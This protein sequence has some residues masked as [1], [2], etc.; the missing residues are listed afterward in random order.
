MADHSSVE[1]LIQN[2]EALIKDGRL[3]EARKLYKQAV[4]QN[5]E[6]VGIRESVLQATKKALDFQTVINQNMALAELFVAR[7]ETDRAIDSYKDILNLEKYAQNNGVRGAQLGEVQNLV[8]RAK[9]EIFAKTG[10]IYLKEKRFK[11][12]IK[13]LRTSLDLDP[14]RWDAHMA[15]GRALMEDNKNKEAIS[16]FQEVVRL[17]KSEAASAY[18]LL[19]EVFLRIGRSPQSTVDWFRNAGELFVQRSEF[20]GAIRAYEKILEF[21][22]RNKDILVRLGEIYSNQGL[23]DKAC[24]T[25]FTLAQ[26]FEEEGFTDRVM[27]YLEKTLDLN[28]AEDVARAKLVEVYKD[29]L[30]KDPGNNALRCRLV[31]NLLHQNN[32]AEAAKHELFLARSYIE[33]GNVDEAVSMLSRLIE[34]EPDNI[35]AHRLMGDQYRRKEMRT[36]SLS[37][38]QIVVGL[39]QKSGRKDESIEFQHQ[40][41]EIF[42]EISDLR[43]QVALSLRDQGNR[44]EA[45]TELE[46]L[47]NSNP[48]DVIALNYLAEEYAAVSKWEESIKAY[49]EI[50]RRDAKRID[51]RKRLIKYYINQSAHNEAYA[52]VMALPSDDF[53]RKTFIYKIIERCLEEDKTSEAEKFISDLSEDDDRLI[54]FRKEL[55]KRYLDLGELLQADRVV[56]LVPRSDKERNK[57]VTRLLELY[58]SSGE[59][60]KAVELIDRLPSDDSLRGSFQRR[61]INSYQESG[62]FED[63]AAEMKKLPEGDDS[64][65]DFMLR[66]ISGLLAADRLVDALSYIKRLDDNDPA[67][68]SFIGQLIEAYLQKND[69][70]G[71][72][73]E[74]ENLPENTEIRARYMCRII[75]AYLNNNRFD[76]AERDIMVLETNDPEKLSFLRLLLQKYEINGLVDRMRALV[77]KLPDEMPEKHQYL[78]GIVQSVLTSGNMA[79]ARQEVYSMAESVASSGNHSEAERLYGDLLAYNPVDV[80]IRMRLCQ[81]VALQGK[82]DRAREGLLVLAG[83]FRREGNATSATDIFSR[84]LAIE[85]DNLNARYRL[86]EIWAQHGQSSQALEQFSFLASEYL[87]Q[88]LNEVAQKVLHRILDLDPKDINHRRQLINLLVRNMRLEDATENYKV[89]LNIHLDRGELEEALNCIREVKQ[90]QP[91]NLELGQQLGGMVL[92]AGFLEEGQQLL[93][94]LVPSYKGRS[95]HN[96]V[97]KIFKTLSDA[98]SDNQQWEAA[99]EYL[100]RV[101]DEQVEAD[102]WKEAQSNYLH[103][104]EEHLMHSRKEYTDTLFVKLVD[105]FFRHKNVTEG[106]EL[107]NGLEEKFRAAGR[108]D[109]A[110]VIKER[111]AGIMER[112][113]DW[114]KAIEVIVYIAETD[115]TIGESE[116]GIAYYRR[117][118]DLAAGHDMFDKSVELAF[119]LVVLVL[120][121]HGFEAARPIF[122]EI[123]EYSNQDPAVIER[124]ADLMFDRGLLEEARPIYEE[125]LQKDPNSPKSISRL[126]VIYNLNE[127]VERAAKLSRKVV[128]GG[129]LSQVVEV[130]TKALNYS[131]SDAIYHIKLGQFFAQLGFLEESIDEFY[132]AVNDP[133]RMLC[134]VNSLSVAFQDKGYKDLAIKQLQRVLD[135]PGFTDDE[136]LELRYNLALIL[137]EEERYDEAIQAYQECYAI[138]IRYRDVEERLQELFEK[139]GDSPL[140][141]DYGDYDYYDGEEQA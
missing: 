110:L 11:E 141:D 40:L 139:V 22:P 23:V 109:L 60:E 44:A 130:Y 55:I 4:E 59:M 6:D 73:R 47:V 42:P 113:G 65:H 21:E 83:R 86:G 95:D 53:E 106:I 36:E 37:E 91:L 27:S 28:D 17:A 52:E 100:E 18:E 76:E 29:N 70:D 115:L 94:E 105:G 9:P 61:L 93:E 63:A 30:Q 123:R 129:L 134:A 99:L 72:A 7:D 104:L 66:Q 97:I 133:T 116:Q 24:R 80:E 75:Q 102:N 107:F 67:R 138:D 137:Q 26:I 41:V 43:Y 132:K 140:D 127:D 3:D 64:Y 81:E 68:N 57:L 5:P 77:L 125:V 126:C 89:L 13:W 19:G 56:T 69:I 12:A 82:I 135:Q 114:S 101:G 25:Y 103:V 33:K 136:L 45:I 71:A 50:L 62:R 10:M 117:G 118:V 119:K 39:L 131:P 108:L 14:S 79:K 58:L 49:R 121:H 120:S 88:N 2:A 15:M 85:P 122:E 92:K 35:D 96:N 74:I 20:T 78:N 124:I 48:D 87:R 32:L 90:L 8:A 112:L 54:S 34:I 1:T 98:F 84:L 31:E 51:V 111:L 38:Y 128:S 46:R 16:E